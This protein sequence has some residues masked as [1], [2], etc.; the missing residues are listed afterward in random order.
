MTT[1]TAH[2]INGALCRVW[3]CVKVFGD[4]PDEGDMDTLAGITLAQ[5]QTATEVIEAINASASFEHGK[6]VVH[7]TMAAEAVADFLEIAQD[8]IARW[9]ARS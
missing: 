8:M 2:K 9:R 7:C 5:A 3:F 6:K 1:E 4:K